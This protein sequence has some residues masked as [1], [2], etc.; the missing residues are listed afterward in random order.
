MKYMVIAWDEDRNTIVLDYE[1][2]NKR[3]AKKEYKLACKVSPY[4]ILI[5]AEVLEEQNL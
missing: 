1:T 3:K 4:V 2:K 5:K